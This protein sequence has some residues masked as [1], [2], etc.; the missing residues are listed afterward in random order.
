M[1]YSVIA[2]EIFFED[3]ERCNMNEWEFPSSSRPLKGESVRSKDGSKAIEI[4][5]AMWYFSKEHGKD[6]LRYTVRMVDA[7]P[8]I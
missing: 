4:L 3:G 6:I 8:I 2:V 5:S 1:N 7:S